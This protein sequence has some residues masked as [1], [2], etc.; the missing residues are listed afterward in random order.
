[1]CCGI[2]STI[3]RFRKF[4]VHIKPTNPL[5]TMKAQLASLFSE[6]DFLLKEAKK[7]FFF[8]KEEHSSAACHCC[9]AIKKYLDAYEKYLFSG[10]APSENYHILLHTII[11][12]D[13]GFKQFSEKI[14]EVKCFAEESKSNADG[15]F[16]Y[17]DEINEVLKII[18]EVRNYIA[19]KIDFRKE[20]LEEYTQTSFMAS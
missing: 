19:A 3:V 14:F 5:T 17:A 4:K 12:K 15:F 7:L 6:G 20:F 16:I 2:F 11:Q 10:I 8:Q 1:M 18:L 13:P 9:K